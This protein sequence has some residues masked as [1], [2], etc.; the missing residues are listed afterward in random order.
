MQRLERLI[1]LVAALLDAD[2]PLTADDLRHRL[3]G[4]A[5]SDGSFRRAFE[6]DKEAL[7]DLGIPVVVEPVDAAVPGVLGYRIP[8]ED[9]YLRDPGLAPDEL[10]ALHLA[11]SAVRLDGAS[12][13]EALWKLGGEVAEGGP[14]AAVAALPGAA[15]LAAVFASISA[16]RPVAFTYRGRRRRVDPWRLSFRNGH[17]YLAGHDH[18]AAE[19]RMFR[20]DR[21]ES[22][23]DV[24]GEEGAFD[25][26]PHAGAQPP[27]WEMG[28]E[29]ALTARL[30]VDAGQAAWAAN[31]VG[32][33]AV[34]AWRPDGSAVLAVRVTNR[35]AFRSFVLGF[36]DHAEVLDPPELRA[37]MVGWL[38]ALTGGEPCPS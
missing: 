13:V 12:G 20:L 17:W 1:N 16:R 35:D 5:E 31:H 37:E 29:E 2:Q 30:L 23:V 15:H 21:I 28:G 22:D 24:A 9:Y 38:Q 6:R 25:R 7:R 11:A 3:P 14:A 26:P 36:L 10:A 18:D 8:K 33:K 19:E 27:P 34:E 32:A 4:Y